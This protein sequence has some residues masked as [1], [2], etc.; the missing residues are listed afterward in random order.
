MMRAAYMPEPGQIAVGDFPKPSVGRDGDVVVRMEAASICGSDIH[1]I[2]DGFHN[3]AALGRPGYPG[4]EG[5][6]VVAESRS[7]LYK[8]GD[9]V[10]TVPRGPEGACFAEY[11]LIP[12]TYLIPV[13][14]GVDVF[15][16]LMAQQ[17]GTALYSMRLFWPE[18]GRSAGTCA[19][20][21]AGS[22]GLFFVQIAK[23]L[24][25]ERVIVSDLNSERLSV[26]KRL[27]ADAV[28]HAPRESLA[29]TVTTMT[30]GVGADLVI[31]AAGYDRCRTEAITAVRMHGIVG[32]FGFPELLGDAPFPQFAAFRKV[33]RIQWAGATQSEPGLV[34]FREALRH[35][36][37][38]SIDVE[39]CLGSSYPLEALPEAVEIARGQGHGKVKLVID[40]APMVA[41]GRD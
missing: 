16:A 8:P 40:I 14:E 13:P 10:L 38:G 20:I 31:E 9:R 30:G 21:G 5:I 1:N 33:V 23:R 26:A 7:S 35:I 15:R 18:E 27:G 17:Y 6:G 4:H 32:F 37:E 2:F 24:G 36:V 22:A 19:I 25:F 41:A 11:Q 3:Q 29:E 28:V 34:S 12:D 39:H